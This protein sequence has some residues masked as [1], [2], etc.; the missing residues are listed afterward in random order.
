MPDMLGTMYQVIR[1]V[2][3]SL[4]HSYKSDIESELK[5]AEEVVLKDEPYQRSYQE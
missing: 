4:G 1:S 5:A 2:I 3:I